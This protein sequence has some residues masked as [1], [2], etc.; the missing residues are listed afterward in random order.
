MRSILPVIRLYRLRNLLPF[1]CVFS[2][3]VTASCSVSRIEMELIHDRGSAADGRIVE[4]VIVTG[5]SM[6]FDE[7]GASYNAARAVVEGND[8]DGH[9]VMIPADSVLYLRTAYSDPGSTLA[10]TFIWIGVITATLV[11]IIAAGY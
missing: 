11:A 1:F 5:R 3:L 4:V 6:V 9:A 10:T 7:T 8:M 2:C